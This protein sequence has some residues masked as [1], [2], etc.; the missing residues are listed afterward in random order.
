MRRTPYKRKE[1]AVEVDEPKVRKKLVIKKEEK[2]E[3]YGH[4]DAPKKEWEVKNEKEWPDFNSKLI[5][6]ADARIDY[7]DTGKGKLETGTPFLDNVYL[8]PGLGYYRGEF[9]LGLPCGQGKVQ[10]LG[11]ENFTDEDYYIGSFGGSY[12][13]SMFNNTELSYIQGFGRLI[14]NI[15][16]NPDIRASAMPADDQLRKTLNR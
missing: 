14:Y 4:S 3:I 13:P 15:A 7:Q 5:L 10:F 11:H 12:K 6:E 1:S 8:I 9:K 2:D 16:L